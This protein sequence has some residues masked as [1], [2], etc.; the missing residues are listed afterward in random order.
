[1]NAHRGRWENFFDSGKP[2]FVELVDADAARRNLTYILSNPLEHALVDR[3]KLWPGA[4]SRPLDMAG[5]VIKASRP[6]GFFLT[7]GPVPEAVEFTLEP[8][9]F[10]A[11][12]KRTKFIEMVSSDL[13]KEERKLRK[14]LTTAKRPILGVKAIRRQD[15][16]AYPK[17]R[18][19]RRKMS[20]R[21]KTRDK[22]RRIE[23]LQRNKQWH[24]AYRDAFLRNQAGEA[25]VLFP[26]G[27][28]WFRI[29]GGVRC[30]PPPTD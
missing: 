12:M 21:V 28:W 6:S 19:P 22:W 9:P 14:K 23:V 1:M 26:Y 7:D 30:R 18:E 16:F 29:Y 5:S 20:P 24:Q 27:T 25:N 17:G 4:W 10:F 2:S 3:S 15:P 13:K 8:S 11:D